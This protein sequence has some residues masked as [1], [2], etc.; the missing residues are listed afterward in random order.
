MCS[1]QFL[2]EKT[3]TSRHDI[4]MSFSME[5]EHMDNRYTTL[6]KK[7]MPTCITSIE[8]YIKY[9]LDL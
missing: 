9:Y 2:I 7:K 5:N 3:W 6:G 1:L 4:F 8:V